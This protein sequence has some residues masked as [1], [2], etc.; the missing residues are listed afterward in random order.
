MI[1][2]LPCLQYG[3]CRNKLLLHCTRKLEQDLADPRNPT[4]AVTSVSNSD[5]SSPQVRSRNN[6]I[7]TLG[8]YSIAAR[9]FSQSWPPHV[10]ILCVVQYS[11]IV[12]LGGNNSLQTLK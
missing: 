9:G 11:W 5:S 6:L 4:A 8:A 2:A 7:V 1:G 3:D 10:R 12:I